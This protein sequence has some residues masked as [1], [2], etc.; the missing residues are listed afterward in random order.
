MAQSVEHPTPGFGSGHDLTVMRSSPRLGSTLME[1]AW[2]SLSPS[3]SASV[4]LSLN[5]N[6]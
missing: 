5:I 2:G 1:L 3:I 4:S 6:T